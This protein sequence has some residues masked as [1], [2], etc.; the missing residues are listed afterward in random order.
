MNRLNFKTTVFLLLLPFCIM[1]QSGN[2]VSLDGRQFKLNGTNFFP[3]AMNYL[4]NIVRDQNGNLFIAPEHSYGPTND[5]ECSG[6]GCTINE[7]DSYNQIVADLQKIKNMGFNSIRLMGLAYGITNNQYPTF[8]SYNSTFQA[9]QTQIAAPYTS[10]FQFIQKA[11]DAASTAGLKVQLFTGGGEVDNPSFS[12]GY[13]SYLQALAAHFAS[14]STLYSYDFLNEPGYFNQINLQKKGQV[15]N[16]VSSW[17]DAI[18]N[19]SS[20]LTTIGLVSSGETFKWDPGFLKLDFLSF[21]LYPYFLASEGYNQQKAI[22]RVK[23]DVKW[24]SQTCELPWIIGETGFTANSDDNY[25]QD[26][27]SLLDQKNYAKQTLEYVRDCMGSGYSWWA[28]QDVWWGSGGNDYFGLVDHSDNAKPA[29]QEFIN[30]NP[31]AIGSN[32]QTPTNYYNYNSYSAYYVY[33]TIKDQN[34]IPIKNAVIMGNDINGGYLGSTYSKDDG[35]FIFYANNPIYKIRATAVKS[36]IYTQTGL[37]NASYLYFS[38]NQYQPIKDITLNGASIS[39]TPNSYVANNSISATNTSVNVNANCTMKATNIVSLKPGFRAYKTST[40]RA[41]IEPVYTDCS[42]GLG[43]NYSRV[44]NSSDVPVTYTK[45]KHEPVFIKAEQNLSV[46]KDVDVPIA[47]YPNP[48]TGIFTIDFNATGTYKIEVVNALGVKIIDKKNA[49]V[50]DTINLSEQSK[51]IYLLTI[52]NDSGNRTSFKL[53][54]E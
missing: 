49:D 44:N 13:I 27:G 31:S 39:G 26:N 3:V 8:T 10:M 46:E 5:Y 15:C 38:L 40:Y 22:D 21:H 53:I 25:T 14:N 23:C 11:L 54:V 45:S 47:V 1:A 7:T 30:F 41:Y 20:H 33:G 36:D 43:S 32:N 48:S 9:Q 18:H 17:N 52:T 42:L 19:N 28:Y 34:N 51:G 12:A 16:L 35:T 2:F 50:R 29:A 6:A 24:I 4:V 37:S